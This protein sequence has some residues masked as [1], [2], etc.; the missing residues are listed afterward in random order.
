[1]PL[2]RSTQRVRLRADRFDTAAAH[3]GLT[4]GGQVADALGVDPATVSRV[5]R[6][7]THPGEAFIAAAITALG[8][9]FEDLFAI[10]EEVPDAAGPDQP[11]G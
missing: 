9:P 6:G 11:Q 4:T 1:M 8:M 10:E 7:L 3:R 5:R 2:T